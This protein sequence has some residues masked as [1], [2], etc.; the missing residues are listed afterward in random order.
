MLPDDLLRVAREVIASSNRGHPADQALRETLQRSRFPFPEDARL[1]ARTVFSYFRWLSWLDQGA[2]LEQQIEEAENLAHRF[3]QNPGSFS[4]ED[5]KIRAVPTWTVHEVDMPASWLRSLQNEPTLWLRARRGQGSV[6][7]EKL[8]N[9]RIPGN[10]ILADTVEYL[11]SEDLFRSPEF[12]AGEFE[13]QDISSQAVGFVCAPR[14]GETWLDA[15]AGEGGKTLHLSDLMENKGL[16]WATDRSHWRLKQLKRRASRARV[17]NYRAALWPDRQPLPTRTKFDGVLVD[18]PC[19]GLGTWQRNP[20]ARWT[21]TRQDIQELAALQEQLLSRVA[22][23]VKENGRLV[24][25]VC[26]IAR[27]ET[28]QLV[29]KFERT[30]PEFEAISVMEPFRSQTSASKQTFIWPGDFGGNGMFVAVWK[31]RRTLSP[32]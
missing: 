18:A 6:L 1:V 17:F 5:L 23:S 30:H 2:P 25:S 27:A 3:A 10:P 8:G 12:H 11:G 24:Y 20:H 13:V 4:S 16:I 22:N 7:A 19:S 9:C 15:C 31:R 28:I 29:E 26:T 14:P 32:E 21:T